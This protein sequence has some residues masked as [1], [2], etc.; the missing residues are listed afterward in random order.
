M[1]LPSSSGKNV[2]YLDKEAIFKILKFFKTYKTKNEWS[3]K[4]LS[5]IIPSPNTF[6]EVFGWASFTESRDIRLVFACVKMSAN[7][8]EWT[9][10]QPNYLDELFSW[11]TH[12][13]ENALAMKPTNYL[14][15]F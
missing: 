8:P 15:L 12:L 7:K 4:Q 6:R 11:D 13:A 3:P 1:D 10:K 9:Q 5:N 2:P 14:N